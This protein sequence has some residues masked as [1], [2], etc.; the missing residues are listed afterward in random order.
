MTIKK[1]VL[2][3]AFLLFLPSLTPSALAEQA[4]EG[5]KTA[6]RETIE[7]VETKVKSNEAFIKAARAAAEASKDKDA[8]AYLK[9]AET[10]SGE[11]IRHYRD[12]EYAFALEDISESNRMA[13]YS[14]V[15]SKVGDDALR[16]HVIK[17]EISLEAEKEH[18]KKEAMIRKGLSEVEI[19]IKTGDRLMNE[20]ENPQARKML[21]EARRLLESSKAHI[22]RNEY[23]SAL[24]EV[25]SAY[26]LATDSVK[27]AKRAGGDIVT[28]P[29]PSFTD[30]ASLLNYEKKRNDTYIFLAERVMKDGNQR[31]MDSLGKAR[32]LREDA[33]KAVDRGDRKEAIE[34]L[35]ASTDI[36]VRALKG[37]LGD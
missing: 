23:D 33:V 7:A 35:K 26:R 13:L 4:V 30:E 5:I 25:N 28:F 12:K 24:D 18:E 34:K 32:S 1:G 2:T 36:L 19:F 37:A 8:I 29:K 17:E 31:A 14:I 6:E 10:L 11:G 9:K 21:D 22:A 3:A 27:E 16:E 15:L 20:T